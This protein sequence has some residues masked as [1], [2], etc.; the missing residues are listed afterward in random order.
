MDKQV[1]ISLT[2]HQ[3]LV[4]LAAKKDR[5]LKDFLEQCINYFKI[6]ELDPKEI[7]AEGI[8]VEI[9]KLDR[10]IVS[11]FKTQEKEKI[12]PILDELS[13]ISKTITNS[14]LASP[15]KSDFTNLS[16]N[17]KEYLDKVA[18]SQNRVAQTFGELR[19]RELR[20]VKNK[21]RAIFNEY[22]AEIE[23]KGTLVSRK[24]IDEKYKKLFE[25]I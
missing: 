4:A 24:P 6:T 15:S 3:I 16:K 10:R 19:L 18:E 23:N 11:F 1:K 14:L 12:A 25:T 17:T 2:S 9:K 22:L 7:D 8:R 20:E 5:S 21:S 13:I